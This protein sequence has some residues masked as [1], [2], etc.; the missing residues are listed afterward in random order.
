M[1]I[2]LLNI[3][4]KKSHLALLSLW[5]DFSRSPALYYIWLI[6]K[7][8][9]SGRVQRRKLHLPAAAGAGGAHTAVE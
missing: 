2:Q 8:R 5:V 1:R 7:A 4:L 9:A 6:K 3:I